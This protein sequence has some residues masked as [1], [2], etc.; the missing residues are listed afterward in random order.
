M[1]EGLERF[2]A[3]FNEFPDCYVIIGGT[4]LQH[5]VSKARFEPRST[6]DIDIVLVIEALSPAFVERFWQFIAD[7]EYTQQQKSEQAQRMYYRFLNPQAKDFP[8]QME[9]FCREPELA[10]ALEHGAHLTPIPVDEGISSL[11]AILMDGDYYRFTIE[12]SVIEGD[13]RITNIESLVCLKARAYLDMIERKEKGEKV[14]GKHIKKHKNDV[15][16]L[17]ALLAANDAYVLPEQL[18]ADL[19]RFVDS[20]A[21]E[22]PDPAIYEEMGMGKLSSKI[23]FESM[24]KVFGLEA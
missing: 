19:S 21:P 22:L 3:Y 1:V 24:Q 9:L 8:V 12:H 18:H 20:I 7:G 13:I 2:R 6:K 11:S 15:F 17:C 16:R 4:A 5:Q 23:I 14:D 10:R